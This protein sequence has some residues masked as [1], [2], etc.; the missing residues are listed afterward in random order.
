MIVI[1]TLDTFGVKMAGP[2]IRVWEMASRLSA[3]HKVRV[4]SFG[5]VQLEAT[6]FEL[7][8]TSVKD[9]KTDLGNPDI[10]ILQGNL[11]ASFPMLAQMDAKLVVDLYDPFHIESLEEGKYDPF[12]EREHSLQVALRE[13]EMQLRAGDYFLCASERQRRLWLGHLAA[14][15]RI[16]PRTYDADP[17]L[18]NLIDLA[19]FGIA[20]QPQQTHHGALEMFQLD[21][22]DPLIVWGGGIY[23]WFDPVTTIRA[24]HLVKEKIPNVRLVF[25][26]AKHPNPSVPK[27]RADTA[28]RAEVAKLHLEENVF[29]NEDWVDYADRHNFL[30]DADV[31]VSAHLPGIETEFSFRTRMLDYLWAGLPIVCSDGDF[32]ADLVRDRKLGRVVPAQDE[33]ALAVAFYDLLSSATEREA[34]QERIAQVAEEFRWGNTLQALVNYCRDPWFAVD[35]EE[36]RKVAVASLPKRSAF[37]LVRRGLRGLREQGFDATM[38]RVRRWAQMR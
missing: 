11:V 35:R 4:L 14:L 13:L 22:A 3:E 15:G 2:A 36:S 21:A 7:V 5:D 10:I 25:M 27:M 1:V 20:P 38:Q 33:K 9:F 18:R 16:N 31:A 24:V 17:T 32:F 12:P 28:A 26:G 6:G 19:P 29:F 30:M 8:A 23:N 37:A 34:C